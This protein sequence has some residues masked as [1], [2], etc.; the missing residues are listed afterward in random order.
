MLSGYL[1]I[2]ISIHNACYRYMD[3]QSFCD[4][5]LEIYLELLVFIKNIQLKIASKY[6]YL[7]EWVRSV[8]KRP[9]IKARISLFTPQTTDGFPRCERKLNPTWRYV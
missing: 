1:L 8:H 7:Y 6:L 2:S 9:F 4:R 3:Y 5:W